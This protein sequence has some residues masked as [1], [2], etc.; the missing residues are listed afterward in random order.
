MSNNVEQTSL[1]NKINSDNEEVTCLGITFKN[2][3]ERRDYFRNELRK[4]LPELKKL[5]PNNIISIGMYSQ[6]ELNVNFG[7]FFLLSLINRC[8][9]C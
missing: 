4:K 1:F 8:I 5:N 6:N 3:N 7:V 2:D 9:K